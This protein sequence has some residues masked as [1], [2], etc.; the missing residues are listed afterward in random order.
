VARHARQF[1]E[2]LPRRAAGSQQEE[3][4]ASYVL[5]HLQRA[6]YLVRLV[7]V[8]VANTVNSIDVVALP[9]SGEYPWAV[10]AVPYDSPPTGG[11]AAGADV[12]LFLE[13][14]RAL[15][16]KDPGHG[17][18]LVAL[19]AEHA[20]VGGGHLGARRLA[21]LLVDEQ[22]EPLVIT[23]ENLGDPL[24]GGFG[25]FGEEVSA[26]TDVARDLDIPVTPLPAPE[27]GEGR[28]LAAR[29]RIFSSAGLEHVAVTGGARAVGRVL[30]EYL[31]EQ[32]SS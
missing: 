15:K 9:P 29:A 10:V 12:G 3:A 5:G 2:E 11:R 17:V 14:G 31:S 23:I 6:G 22:Q 20:P 8:P 18:E 16:V 4:A 13:L 1:D 32:P 26:L 30:L 24:E 19:G 27:L 28:D 7:A 21:A 25:A